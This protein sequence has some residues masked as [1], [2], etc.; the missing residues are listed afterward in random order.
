MGFSISEIVQS[1]GYKNFMKYLYGWGAAVVLVGALFKLQHWPGAGIMLTVGMSVEAIIF[2]FSAFEPLVEEVDWSIV[3]PELA[4]MTEGEGSRRE[5]GGGCM[6]PGLLERVIT[7]AL[8]KSKLNVGTVS[9]SP[10]V[11][12]APVKAPAQQQ[13]G[14][15]YAA[16]AGALVFTEK[17]NEMLESAKIGPE[18]FTKIGSG[19]ER[20]SEASNGI[21]KIGDAVAASD[22]FS[23][24]LQRAG[25]AVGKFAESYENSGA[26][27][28]RSAQVLSQS[29]ETSATAIS[30]SG[31]DFEGGIT[32]IVKQMSGSLSGVTDSL[33][34]G[35]SASSKQLQTFNQSIEAMNAAHEL[36]VK[37]IQAR[38]KDGEKLSSGVEE[39]VRQ[40]MATVQESE[41]YG[42][43]VSMLTSNVSKLN[44]IYGNMLSAMGGVADRK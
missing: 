30:K 2:F 39:M 28:A 8:S 5:N 35:V 7:N 38:L 9:E 14:P 16:P 24:N 29:F 33:K 42:K 36:Q 41:Q 20:L 10:A 26:L 18:L 6:D 1:S 3:Y 31:K 32:E 44:N 15:N 43:A 11:A 19:L 34:Q 21:A 12:Q 17:F 23:K 40:L 27:L 22:T 25:G 37:Q 13:G 4:G